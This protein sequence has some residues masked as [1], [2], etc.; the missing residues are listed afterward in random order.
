MDDPDVLI[1]DEPTSGLDPL[2][3][4]V[5]INFVRKE[6]LRGKTILLSSHIFAEV[7][8]TCDEIA[9][10][11]DGKHVSSFVANDLKHPYT[12]NYLVKVDKQ[13]EAQLLNE[14]LK[15]SKQADGFLNIESPD[16]ETDETL[17]ILS[18]YHLLDFKEQEF[19]LESYFMSF[20]KEK[21]TFTDLNGIEGNGGNAK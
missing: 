15:I 21:K 5:F 10:I 12:R 4:T 11:K 8:A 14:K 16:S 1:L 6:K 20:Y 2:M 19:S 13:E 3:Q 17:K 9:I 18:N 7:D